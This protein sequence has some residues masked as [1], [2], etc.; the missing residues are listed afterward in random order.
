MS[1]SNLTINPLSNYNLNQ[2]TVIHELQQRAYQYEANLIGVT[3]FP[4]LSRTVDDVLNSTDMFYGGTINHKI[5]GLIVLEPNT[6]YL[7]ISSLVVDPAYHRQGI[8]LTLVE[9]VLQCYG[10]TTIEVGTAT[11]NVPAIQ[12]YERCGFQIIKRFSTPQGLQLVRLRRSS[13]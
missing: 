13:D 11:N 2:A 1:K 10:D 12:L 4:P 6:N 7:L 5:V 9:Y 3:T 8:G